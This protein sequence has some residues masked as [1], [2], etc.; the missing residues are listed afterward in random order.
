ME[1]FLERAQEEEN[2]ARSLEQLTRQE[3]DQDE[4]R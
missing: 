4:D 3:T 2:L 1:N